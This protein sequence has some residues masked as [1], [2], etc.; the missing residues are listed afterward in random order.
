[1]RTLMCLLALAGLAGGAEKTELAADGLKEPFGLAFLGKDVMLTDY[2][3]HRVILISPEGKTTVLVGG[4][5]AGMADGVGEAASLN[6]P[7][8]LSMLPDGRV[9]I[10]DTMGHR[11]RLLDPKSKLL[12][13][14]GGGEKGFAG[15]GGPVSQAKFDQLY[16]VAVSPKGDVLFICDLG[17]R[18]IRQV[19]LTK[20]TI[21]TVAGNG[22][23]G[24]PVDGE[25]AVDQPLVDPRAVEPDAKG[26]LWILERGGH[27]LRVVENGKIRTVAGTGQAGFAGDDGPALKAKLN[28][29]KNLFV[30]PAG[31]V[32]IADTENHCIR[33]YDPTT[34]T[35]KRVMGTG[36]S[37][38]GEAGGLPTETALKRP[39][40]VA[41]DATGTMYV[42][43]SDNGRVL[44]V[45]KNERKE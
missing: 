30:T 11:L 13:T 9:Y 40:A 16:H 15:D 45:A 27:A 32:L 2:G 12:T 29:P 38:K 23:K 8:N 5:K 22:K 42:S 19:E 7:H 44:K 24:V 20:F 41:L 26:R 39:H 25:P 43:D 21:T 18:R 4:G 36:K 37:G 10:A 35:I 34:Q 17:N 28:G 6:G 31:T 33:E 1:M 3:G 14:V